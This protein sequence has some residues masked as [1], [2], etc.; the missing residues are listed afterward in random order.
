MLITDI[1][2]L[3]KLDYTM[4]MRRGVILTIM[5]SLPIVSFTYLVLTDEVDFSVFAE[6]FFIGLEKTQK[7]ETNLQTNIGEKIA[8]LANSTSFSS[9]ELPL[10]SAH[11]GT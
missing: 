7:F 5:V 10:T 8:N 2:I 11:A 6:R 1:F 9:G 3:E 4:N